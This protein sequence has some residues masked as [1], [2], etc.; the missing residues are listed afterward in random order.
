[1][2]L[3]FSV[4]LSEVACQWLQSSLKAP[5]S[6]RT[7]RPC[8]TPTVCRDRAVLDPVSGEHR[9][10]SSTVTGKNRTL[11][12]PV[13]FPQISISMPNTTVQNTAAVSQSSLVARCLVSLLSRE[14]LMMDYRLL[15]RFD[16][17]IK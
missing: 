8:A 16:A 14:H 3:F 11:V 6:Q 15:N 7:L 13:L 1:M 5:I 2:H 10:I 4:L 9:S 17:L 12:R